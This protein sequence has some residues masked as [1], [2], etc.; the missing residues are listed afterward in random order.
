MNNILLLTKVFLK[1][2]IFKNYSSK[3]EDNKSKRVMKIIGF[4]LI[5][6]YVIGIFGFLSYEMIQ[7]LLI[8]NQ[9]GLFLGTFLLAV[10]VLILIQSIVSSMNLF[11][12]S[13]DVENILPL[14]IKPYQI[15]IAKFNVLLVTE[16]ITVLLFALA[17]FIIYGI[18]TGAGLL[19]YLYG[20]IVL[21][22]FPIVPALI[23]SLLVIILMSFSKNIKNKEK[24]QIV[25]SLLLIVLVIGIQFGFSGQQ[26]MNEEEIAGMFM[27]ANGMIDIIDNYFITLKPAI[28]ALLAYNTSEAL[29]SLLELITITVG[30]YAVFTIVS[31]KLY[32]KGAVGALASSGGKKARIRVG[33]FK[34]KT[35]Q[36][37]YVK[38]EFIM[39]FKN[40]I[41]FMQCVLPALIMPIIFGG[42][43]L[44]QQNEFASQMQDIDA[45]QNIILTI[46]V[47]MSTFMLTMIF[48]PV[49]AISRDGTYASFV[50]YIPVSFYKQ[51]QYKVIPSIVISVVPI[52]IIN[53]IAY[54][55]ADV[56][57][58]IL[59]FSFIIS[60]VVS[61]LYSY[62]MFIVD[63][64]R[65][66]L[67]WDTEYAVVKQNMN[68][69]FGFVFVIAYIMLLVVIGSICAEANFAT[70]VIVLLTIT[71]SALIGIDRYV[72]YNQG[73]LFKKIV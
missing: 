43:F 26:E 10:G 5:Y 57:I 52:V 38:K 3:T 65:P 32:L 2:S 40:P 24:M 18:L 69:F 12:F 62:I 53:I 70:L 30:I 31:Q 14:P 21:L 44:L 67:N 29:V 8:V 20:I 6:I 54:I 46:L 51:F 7:S 39:L 37:S 55:I 47:G 50:K 25:A 35:I 42:V 28:N 23:S 45:N 19:F 34:Q 60:L 64:K 56:D 1:N 58:V 13:K 71:G 9:A 66:K 27:K 36:I 11:Y 33:A 17:P 73:E 48:I 4:A 41:Y 15:L 72:Y 63:L 22:T 68:M 49:T 61:I 16:Y 59:V